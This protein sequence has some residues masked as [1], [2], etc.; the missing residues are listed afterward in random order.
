MQANSK[1]KST[2]LITMDVPTWLEIASQQQTLP[3]PVSLLPY[4]Y[5]QS[6]VGK[7]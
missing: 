7:R 2:R 3:L 6:M 5:H 1:E 4:S